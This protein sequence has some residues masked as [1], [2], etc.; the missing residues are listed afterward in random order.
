MA[1]IGT[2]QEYATYSDTVLYDVFYESGTMLGG[3]LIACAR[4]AEARGDYE[5]EAGFREEMFTADR[6]RASVGATD[7]DE[8]VRV[9][10]QF[11]TR[12]VELKPVLV[13]LKG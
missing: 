6:L 4:A 13:R 8:Q 1:E 5:A 7:R 10:I 11:Q 9:M 3:R 12:R 2:P